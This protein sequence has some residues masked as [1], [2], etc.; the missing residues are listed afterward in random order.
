MSRFIN[1]YTDFGFKK[2]FGEEANKDLL[3]DFLN[4]FLPNKHQVKTLEFRN[5]E[6]LGESASDRRAVFDVFCDAQNGDKIIV[7]MQKEDQ[8]YFK[9]RSV[10]YSTHLIQEQGQK[11]KWNYKLKAVYFIGILDFLYEKK[12]K[13][14]VLIRRVTLKDQFGKEFYKKLRCIYIQMPI[15]DLFG[16]IKLVHLAKLG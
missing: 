15:L 7:E 12:S 4:A 10:F 9:D 11:G 8:E 16:N 13:C 14:P 3:I 6:H 5:P 2:L 1:P